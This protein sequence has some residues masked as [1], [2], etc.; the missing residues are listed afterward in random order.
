A[1]VLFDVTGYY[2]PGSG[3]L[4]FFALNPGRGLDGRPGINLGLPGPFNANVGRTLHVDGHL[5]VPPGAAAIT[6]N[7]TVTGQTKA[8]FAA[9]TPDPNNNPTTST[10]NFP[11][12]DNRANGV[13]VPPNGSGE[14]SLVYKASVGT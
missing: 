11:L 12:A 9:I 3:G 8:G 13:T 4:R 1:H 5:G 10:I 14:M 6:G 2:V 7:L